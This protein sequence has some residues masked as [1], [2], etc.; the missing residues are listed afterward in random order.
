MLAVNYAN[1]H[2]LSKCKVTINVYTV[3]A[4]TCIGTPRNNLINSN[5]D[6]STRVNKKGI[7]NYLVLL[8]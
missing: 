5:L 4:F 1:C 7:V 2:Y 6:R 8:T 3:V